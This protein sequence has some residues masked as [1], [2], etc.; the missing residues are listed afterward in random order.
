[1]RDM[2]VGQFFQYPGTSGKFITG[3]DRPGK[4]GR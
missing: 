3:V 2:H 4:P 1:M